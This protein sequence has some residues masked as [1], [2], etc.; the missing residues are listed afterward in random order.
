M[1][2]NYLGGQ[3]PRRVNFAAKIAARWIEQDIHGGELINC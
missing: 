3:N 1:G 2:I